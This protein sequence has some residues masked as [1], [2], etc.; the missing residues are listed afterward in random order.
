MKKFL[1]TATAFTLLAGGA[2]AATIDAATE[3]KTTCLKCHSDK[4]SRVS[5]TNSKWTG[6][7][8]SKVSTAVYD[9][10]TL[11]KTGKTCSGATTVPT[12]TTPTGTSAASAHAG[13]TSYNGPATCIA[14]HP[15]QAQGMLNSLHMQWAGKTPELTNAPNQTLGKGV[16]GIN[17]FC[18]YAMSS[19]GA[20]F[21]C[22]VRADGNAPHAPSLND[23]DCLMCHNDTYQ[24]KTT[25]DPSTAMTITD[26]LGKVKTYIFG[27]RDAQGNYFTEPDYALM[28]AGTTMVGLAKTVH[29]PTRKSCLRCHAKAGG[30]DWTK[31]GDMGVNTAAPTDAQD[32]HMSPT[33][34]NLTCADCHAVSGHK[35]SGRGIDLRQTEA[36][37]PKCQDCHGTS[38]HKSTDANYTKLN[39][40]ATGQ[41]ACQTCHIKTFAKGGAT[42]MSRDWLK[43]EWNPGFCNGQGGWI[44]T[45]VKVANVKPE[46]R[47]FDGTSYVYNVGEKITKNSDGTYTMAKANGKIFDGKSKIV[48]IKN[49]KTNI[50][51]LSDGRIIPPAIMWMFMTGDFNQAVQKGM[52]DQGMTGSYTMVNANA[53]MLITHGVDPKTLAP[54]C[55]ECHGSM[56]GHNN[57]MVPFTQLG[58]HT[59][60]TSVKGC[61]M[62]HEKKTLSWE[63]THD[64]H[65]SKFAC[66]SCHTAPPTGL[67]SVTS[68]LCKS[69]HSLESASSQEVHKEHVGKYAC[70]KCHKF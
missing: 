58:Y 30:G 29:M 19:G 20:C 8:V 60:P 46:Y 1:F 62:C 10:V 50:P 3:L 17:T 23:V 65:R 27:L 21:N 52:K 36:P 9:A 70:S 7:N 32:V 39:R 47:W 41:V 11:Y 69:C 31:R 18:T 33:R 12:T 38:P 15:T 42:E 44:G 43:P 22:H 57:L 16:K 4:S 59:M 54:K 61:T 51:L 55:A 6:H 63:G 67:V 45:E 49:H 40:H 26:Y 68:T 37:D 64:T 28:P 5:C 25:P 13:I 14:C 53:E 48:P 66:S 35:I 34:G 56:T 24:R 2:H